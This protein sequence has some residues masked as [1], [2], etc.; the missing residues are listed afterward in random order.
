MN[1]NRLLLGALAGFVGFF[2]AGY[3]C[4]D[5][6]FGDLLAST[7]PGMASVQVEPNIVAIIISNLASGLVL[8][9]IFERWARIRSVYTGAAAGAII[10]LLTTLSYDSMIH[11]TTSLMTWNGVFVDTF[12]YTL[13]SAV[14]GAF[15]AFG[16]SYKRV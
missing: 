5:V 15:T 16:L 9:Y 11:G 1:T 8:A 3:L 14:G 6:L 4:Y 12:V 2:V 7:N 10:G 13:I